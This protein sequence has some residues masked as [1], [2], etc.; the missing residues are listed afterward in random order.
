MQVRVSHI[1]VSSKEEIENLKNQINE[2]VEFATL[3]TKHSKCPS[4]QRGGDLGS[5]GKGM[6]VKP[7][8]D[9]AFSLPVG[10]VSDTVETQFG[11]HLIYRTA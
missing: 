4:G 10:G 5:F 2:G 7:F 9:V 8:E 6:M 1:L 3:A 11:Y